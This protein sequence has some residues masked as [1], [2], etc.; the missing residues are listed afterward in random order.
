[1]SKPVSEIDTFI[2]ADEATFKL[3]FFH[4]GALSVLL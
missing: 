3:R 1:M 4:V 2:G